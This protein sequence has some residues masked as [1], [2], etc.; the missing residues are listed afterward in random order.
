MKLCYGLSTF[1]LSWEFGGD[2]SQEP[3]CIAETT[4]AYCSTSKISSINLSLYLNI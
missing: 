3:A 4:Y 2:L 1:G